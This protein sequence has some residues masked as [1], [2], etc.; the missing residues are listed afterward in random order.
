MASYLTHMPTG[1]LIEFWVVGRDN[2]PMSGEEC[3][4][5]LDREEKRL[6]M[7]LALRQRDSAMEL[8]IRKF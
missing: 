7:R 5:V 6:D 1:I 8:H 4:S 3:S 2:S